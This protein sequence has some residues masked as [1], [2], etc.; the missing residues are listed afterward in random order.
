MK[1]IRNRNSLHQE[2]HNLR[3]KTID[4]G[5]VPTM[6]AIHEG[7]ISLIQNSIKENNITICSIYVNPKQFNDKKDLINYPRDLIGDIRKL[8]QANCDILF[9]PSDSDIYPNN[10]QDRDYNFTN[11][12][13]ILEGQRRKGH[14]KG[15]LNVVQILFE[16]VQPTRAYF[17]EKDYQQ[18]WII[19]SFQKTYK[20]SLSIQ[21]VQTIRDSEGLALSSRNKHLSEVQKNI[22]L[23]L[24]QS[25]ILFKYKIEQCCKASTS[26]F[27]E[28]NKLQEIRLNVLKPILTN[29]SIKL[30]YFE[31]IEVENFSF[32]TNLHCDKQYRVLIAAYLGKVRL[33]DNISIN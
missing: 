10:F 4:I 18:L 15:V 14:F 7:H 22:A 30:D 33:I 24:Y 9:L 1:V 32:V 13:N 12:L 21:P 8:E 3:K 26:L 23:H 17:G 28:K 5:F 20:L 2:L 27:I 29:S 19:M 25:L 11:V 16:L 31:I 6:G